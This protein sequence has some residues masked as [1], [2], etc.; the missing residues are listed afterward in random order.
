MPPTTS[1]AIDHITITWAYTEIV[2]EDDYE[3]DMFGDR[4][5]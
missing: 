5:T 3:F 2:E 4:E 1:G